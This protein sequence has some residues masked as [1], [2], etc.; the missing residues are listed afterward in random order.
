MKQTDTPEIVAE[1]CETDDGAIVVSTSVTALQN[2]TTASIYCSIKGDTA[3]DKKIIFN[4]I[5]N[6]ESL[7]ENIGMVFA[8]KDVIALPVTV[9]SLQEAGVMVDG[10]RIVLV[11]DSGV[12]YGC[13][14]TGVLGALERLFSIY[15]QPGEWDAPLPVMAVK[16]RGKKGL[17]FTTLELA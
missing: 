9:E 4:A 1:V 12:C 17:E 7:A 5:N 3:E 16:R 6:S 14:S 10:T 2:T 15:G 13:M 8:L 11:T